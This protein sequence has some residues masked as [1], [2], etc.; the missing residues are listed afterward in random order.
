MVR[1]KHN[2]YQARRFIKE[3]CNK[4]FE[5]QL[6][7]LKELIQLWPQIKKQTTQL[8]QHKFIQD[9]VNN[10]LHS[11]N[12]LTNANTKY[13]PEPFNW[14]MKNDNGGFKELIPWIQTYLTK[15]KPMPKETTL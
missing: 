14:M 1:D 10:Q 8:T 6:E 13:R 5:N 12:N 3:Q 7:L 2:M 4:Q 11:P 9:K 15:Y